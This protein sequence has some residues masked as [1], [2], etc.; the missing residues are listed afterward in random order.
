[1]NSD[2]TKF[3]MYLEIFMKFNTKGY[4]YYSKYFLPMCAVQVFVKFQKSVNNYSDTWTNSYV[5]KFPFPTK[6]IPT[7]EFSNI[8]VSLNIRYVITHNPYYERN[9]A[10]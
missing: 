2:E 3:N 7:F 4:Q 5:F 9:V 8:P 6:K 10:S 1:M